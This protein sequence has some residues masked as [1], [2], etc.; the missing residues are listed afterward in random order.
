MKTVA[1]LRVSTDEQA[2]SGLGLEAQLEAITKKFGAPDAVYQ[3]EVSGSKA[4]RVGLLAALDTL[5]RGDV[6][7]VAK[8]DRLSRDVYLSCWIEKEAKK[9]G[10]EIRSAA[11]EG[12]EG[13]DPVNSLMRHIVDAFAQYE[14]EIIGQRT[15]AA[16]RQKKRKGE[17]TGGAVPFGYSERIGEDGVKRLVADPDEQKIIE[18]VSNLKNSGYSLRQIARELEADGITSKG[19]SKV[20]SAE[21]VKRIVLRKADTALMAAQV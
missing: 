2:Q 11:G 17:K 1:Y 16:L 13:S 5:R 14:R 7:A 20:W 12:T 4:D 15:A 19:G 3:D 8:R 18:D 6:L 21:K 10:A 9:R